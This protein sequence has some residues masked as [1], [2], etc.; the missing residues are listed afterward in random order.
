MSVKAYH[1]TSGYHWE[2]IKRDGV[3]KKGFNLNDDSGAI[4]V[5]VCSDKQDSINEWAGWVASRHCARSETILAC[6]EIEIPEK[7]LDKLHPDPVTNNIRLEGSYVEGYGDDWYFENEIPVD[8]VKAVYPVKRYYR[9]RDTR[10]ILTPMEYMTT[11][12][13]MDM[14]AIWDEKFRFMDEDIL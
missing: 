3:I 5:F 13:Y 12:D 2:C 6:L 11:L 4:G 10:Q 9:H 1:M 7:E 8:W 14:G